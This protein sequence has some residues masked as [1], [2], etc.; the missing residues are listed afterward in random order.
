MNLA[1]ELQIIETRLT[2]DE[3]D[4]IQAV[5][6]QLRRPPSVILCTQEQ[7]NDIR[8]FCSTDTA[9]A[10]RSVLSFDRTFNLSSLYLSL[11][12]I[13]HRKIVRKSTQKPPV[14]V[15]SM[16]LHGDGKYATYLNF[17]IVNGALNGTEVSASEFRLNDNVVVGLDDENAMVSAA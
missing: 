9:P 16:L 14:F 6:V 7:I 17:S 3:E 1:D 10:L 13:K 2:H 4:F 5:N 15:G 12:V 8:L 11:M